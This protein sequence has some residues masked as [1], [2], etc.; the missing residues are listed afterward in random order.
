MPPQWIIPEG[1]SYSRGPSLRLDSLA[2]LILDGLERWV[3]QADKALSASYGD[4]SAYL[5]LERRREPSRQL[6]RPMEFSRTRVT[7]R[8]TRALET[9]EKCARFKENERRAIEDPRVGKGA[10]DWR[11]ILN[12]SA[13]P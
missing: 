6:A 1:S 9:S 8:P 10:K 11:N 3:K 4:F 2:A 12:L 7:S 13:K 5:Y